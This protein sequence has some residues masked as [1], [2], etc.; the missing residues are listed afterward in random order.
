VQV[1]HKFGRNN[2]VG[3][4]WEDVWIRGGTYAWPT[5]ATQLRISSSTA[6][7]TSTGL[8]AQTVTLEGLD[9]NFVPITETV[10]L[11]GVSTAVTTQSFIRMNRAY[12]ETAGSYN[13]LT[14]GGNAGTLTINTGT[15]AAMASIDVESSVGMGQ[16]QIARYTVPSGL[17]GYIESVVVSVDSA[18]AADFAFFKR[19][20]AN[21]TTGSFGARRLQMQFD[22]INT[23]LFINPHTALGPY[24]AMTDLWWAAK[25]GANTEI[26]VD[27]EIILSPTTFERS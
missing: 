23:E 5:A 6:A 10:D 12:V 24:P 3:A 15:S 21:N 26:S 16:T 18:Q 25:A 20:N 27:M 17:F 22:A 4:A 8:G 9:A 13:T 2:A 19:L 7:D 11:A 1:V 14:A